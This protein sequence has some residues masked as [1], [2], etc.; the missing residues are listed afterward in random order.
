MEV[1][2]YIAKQPAARKAMLMKLKKFLVKKTGDK[3]RMEYG[4]PC[5][6]VYY[7][8]GLKDHVNM[9]FPIKGMTKEELKLFEGGG[10]TY[11]H[12]KFYS[13]KDIDEKKISKL[14]RRIE[15]K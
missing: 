15:S 10:K 3:G 11:R 8:V 4:V 13:L 2:E 6:G 9:G 5:F 14:M 1:D 12:I 7:I